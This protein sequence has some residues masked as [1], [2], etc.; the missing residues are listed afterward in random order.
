MSDPLG[1]ICK[2]AAQ[3]TRADR[4]SIPRPPHSFIGTIMESHGATTPNNL[5][6]IYGE[7]SYSL[8]LSFSIITNISS[9]PFPLCSL[10]DLL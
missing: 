8:Y 3:V 7:F 9:F 6:S 4:A 5:L 10:N 1:T 2:Y